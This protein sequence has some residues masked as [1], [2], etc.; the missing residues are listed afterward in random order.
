MAATNEAITINNMKPTSKKTGDLFFYKEDK[1]EKDSEKS[2]EVA[3]ALFINLKNDLVNVYDDKN[4]SSCQN[5]NNANNSGDFSA[6]KQ[7]TE[8]PSEKKMS[9]IRVFTT[10][11]HNLE[12]N[13]PNKRYELGTQKK[14]MK[15]SNL[16]I[17]IEK[18]L[19]NFNQN[20]TAN[21]VRESK[22]CHNITQLN[23]STKNK[24][25]KTFVF[26][27]FEANHSLNE[28][29]FFAKTTKH[30]DEKKPAVMNS[31][32]PANKVNYAN[33]I[34]GN[35]KHERIKSLDFNKN[36]WLLKSEDGDL[37]KKLHYQKI[38]LINNEE[39]MF[40]IKEVLDC[41]IKKDEGMKGRKKFL[42]ADIPYFKN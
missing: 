14:E 16:T 27:D 22:E 23:G 34:V 7:K 36:N 33:K 18:N 26:Q 25:K 10:H 21:K 12:A 41:N 30:I 35:N 28:T 19:E 6:N 17:K 8:I 32:F 39:V 15:K 40:R 24:S 13:M 31:F 20:I 9:Q 2:I 11:L 4:N 42:D 29:K 1:D 5:S 3:K 37:L 38:D